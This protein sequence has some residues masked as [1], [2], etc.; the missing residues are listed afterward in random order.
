MPEHHR[1]HSVILL[2]QLLRLE[3]PPARGT[4]CARDVR[5]LLAA[6]AAHHDV[7]IRLVGAAGT[8]AG[9]ALGL[10]LLELAA[11][12]VL[13]LAAKAA[14]TLRVLPAQVL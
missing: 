10:G 7:A 1:L 9:P 3:M 11:V 2:E 5:S 14:R 13:D 8:R 12:L 4:L 6:A